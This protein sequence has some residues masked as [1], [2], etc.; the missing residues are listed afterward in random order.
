M[1]TF[2]ATAF[3][4]AL[5]VLWFSNGIGA[6]EPQCRELPVQAKAA[7]KKHATEIRGAEY[8]RYRDV[9]EGDLDGDGAIDLAIAYNIEGVCHDQPGRPGAC[10]NNHTTFLTVFL[11][12]G[13]GYE[14]IPFIQVGGKGRR[15]IASV[16][17]IDRR[18]EADT[19][20]YG[21]RDALC[22][23]SK[24]GRTRFALTVR[25]LSEEALT[26]P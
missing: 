6:S 8:C 24:K 7:I 26:R 1:K 18:I 11:R 23:P 16:S 2:T 14:Q 5:C 10:E 25:G 17:I 13:T 20:E 15:S 12:R 19:L 4:V 3:V 9:A 22:C 21:D